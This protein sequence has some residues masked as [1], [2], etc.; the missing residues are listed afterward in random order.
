MCSKRNRRF[1]EI[2]ES[3]ISTKLTSCKCKYKFDGRK[4]SPNQKWNSNKCRCKCKKNHTCE[5]DYVWNPPTC[6][7]KNGKYLASI[8]C[9]SVITCDETIQETKTIPTSFNAKNIICETKKNIQLTFLLITIAL[10]IAV[11]IY[12]YLIKYK[13]K[14]KAFVTY[15]VANNKLKEFF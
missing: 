3:K 13:A 7:C 10:L 6:S 8:V 15:Y 4:F 11:S 5:I 12:F 14:Q 9:D 1:T 2:S